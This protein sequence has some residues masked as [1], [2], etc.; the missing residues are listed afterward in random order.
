MSARG[1]RSLRRG[2]LNY[3]S[4][5]D[6][7]SEYEPPQKLA[8]GQ[9]PAFLAKLWKIVNDEE[10][11]NVHWG[12]E[13]D[14]FIVNDQDIFSKKILPN[15]FKHQR[16]NSFVRQLN[17]YGFKKVPKVNLKNKSFIF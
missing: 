9:P 1:F 14:S 6:Y 7:L 8:S 11:P 12:P 17:M 15:Y 10:I 16:M 2:I 4:D 3:D 5:E 13:G